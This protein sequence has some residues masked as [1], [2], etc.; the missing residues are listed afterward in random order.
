[1]MGTLI[2]NGLMAKFLNKFTT[3]LSEYFFP[4]MLLSA[5]QDFKMSIF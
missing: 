1:M 2:D 5:P 3:L 4:V